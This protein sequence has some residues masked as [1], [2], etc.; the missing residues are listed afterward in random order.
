MY[1]RR[2]VGA[3]DW[4]VTGKAEGRVRGVWLDGVA[5]GQPE[6]VQPLSRWAVLTLKRT[7]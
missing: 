3:L 7:E 5:Q 2:K 1:P 6:D 4:E